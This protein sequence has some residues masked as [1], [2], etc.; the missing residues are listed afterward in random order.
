MNVLEKF[1]GN[2]LE[3]SVLFDK[4]FKHINTIKNYYK[5]KY[6]ARF[7]DYR[8][9]NIK[10]LEENIDRKVA[11]IPVS[12]QLAVIDKSDLL[13]SSGYNSL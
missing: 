9:I 13:V 3:V 2:D 5:G 10:K 1:Y 8:R 7:G 4:F 12:K 6:E 11:R